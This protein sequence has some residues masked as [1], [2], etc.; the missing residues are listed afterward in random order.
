MYWSVCLSP[1]RTLPSNCPCMLSATFS[2]L[3]ASRTVRHVVPASGARLEL[4]KYR[5]HGLHEVVRFRTVA[6]RGAPELTT[7]EPRKTTT[8]YTTSAFLLLGAVRTSR[9][10]ARSPP[11]PTV[12]QYHAHVLGLPNRKGNVEARKD[13]REKKKECQTRMKELFHA[14][15]S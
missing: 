10:A 5:E 15:E 8:T 2:E 7:N 9:F 4:A 13:R 3:I 1:V 14:P 11:S 6:H 12:L